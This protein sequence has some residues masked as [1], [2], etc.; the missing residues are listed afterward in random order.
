MNTFGN[1]LRLTTFGE[2]HGTAIG[3]VIDGFPSGFKIDFDELYSEVEKRRPGTSLSVSLRNEM[4]KPKFLSGINENGVT[5]GTPIGFIIHNVDAK[6]KDYLGVSDKYRPN[7][8]D[9]TYEVK[10]GLRDYKGGGR[11]SARETANW[12]VAGALA[13][14]WLKKRGIYIYTELSGAG[15][16]S[17]SSELKKSLAF[18]PLDNLKLIIPENIKRE[19]EQEIHNAKDSGDSVGGTVTCLICGVPPGIGEPVG[20]KLHARLAYAMMSINAA[21][22][23]EYGLGCE[24]GSKYGSEILDIFTTDAFGN[25]V[26]KTNFSGGIQ[27]GIT[28]GMPIYFNV[29]FKPT[30]TISREI[31]TINNNHKETILI[32]KGRHDP[33]VAV[34]AVPVVK[35]MAALVLADFLL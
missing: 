5:L 35:S 23:F 26:T 4:D 10:Y 21:K 27:G 8:A 29:V 20:D 12:V 14:Q 19:L 28:N 9:F 1:K 22:G 17:Y 13:N 11:A 16:I 33:C 32:M 2:S 3:G 30:P 15:K 34:R 25:V 31:P 6:E 24:T 18:K 7:H